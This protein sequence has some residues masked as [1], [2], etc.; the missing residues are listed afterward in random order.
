MRYGFGTKAA[1]QE[2][3]I[4]KNFIGFISI[5]LLII[6]FVSCKSTQTESTSSKSPSNKNNGI[7]VLYCRDSGEVYYQEDENEI[8]NIL[9]LLPKT[10]NVKYST[11][12]RLKKLIL[13]NVRAHHSHFLYLTNDSGIKKEI[14]IS[15]EDNIWDYK[16]GFEYHYFPSEGIEKIISKMN[17]G[18]KNIATF[19]K[20]NERRQFVEK[21]R[22][23]SK[24]LYMK[25]EPDFDIIMGTF[26]IYVPAA[27]QE[28]IS[29][30]EVE[31]NLTSLYG[32]AQ[33]FFWKK[34]KI[35]NN[36]AISQPRRYIEESQEAELEIRGTK[37]LYDKIDIYR[38]G[39]FIEDN[40]YKTVE[41][42]TKY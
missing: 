6:F 8:K 3:N 16:D 20:A 41:Y 22:A 9:S 29:Q 33:R 4:K 27:N 23:D 14:D 5:L 39:E 25:L 21:L 30:I 36:F 38:K 12:L 32:E 17:K 13:L 35:L 37:E 40:Y 1:L 26:K 7:L 42:Y 11:K 2:S 24:V 18:I 10:L 19:E 15:V 31:K 34:E 28:A